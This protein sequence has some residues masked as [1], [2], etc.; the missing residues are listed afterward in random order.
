MRLR[1]P[2]GQTV[3]LASMLS[4]QSD[5]EVRGVFTRLADVRDAQRDADLQCLSLIINPSFASAL[6]GSIGMR[7][8]LQYGL[9]SRGYEVV[10]LGSA[11]P[12][13]SWRSWWTHVLD[14]ARVL[15][16]L[17]PEDTTHGS[18][19]T[20]VPSFGD[21]PWESAARELD[22]LSSGLTEIA[23]HTGSF[24]R[25]AC[26]MAEGTLLETIDDAV[27]LLSAV[28]PTRVGVCLSPDRLASTSETPA[29]ALVKLRRAH[30]AVV[31]VMLT[32]KAEA[33]T[34]AT[35]SALLGGPHPICDHYEAANAGALESARDEFAILGLHGAL[36]R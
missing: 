1:H 29:Q 15:A 14:L 18:I 5:H 26:E 23:W 17:L 4:S 27:R 25:V 34:R 7:R 31:K 32:D 9:A 19:S 24:V 20:T 30:L 28:D 10:T 21:D 35:L 12:H 11:F 33:A 36:L 8:R 22:D 2:D 6:A 13:R 16:D 3:Y